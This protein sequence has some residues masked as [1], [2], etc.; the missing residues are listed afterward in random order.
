AISGFENRGSVSAVG[1]KA[2]GILVSDAEFGLGGIRNSGTIKADGTAI[3]LEAFS[4]SQ[5]T[6]DKG[7]HFLKIYQGGG[8]IEGGVAAID[9]RDY[10]GDASKTDLIWSGGTIRGDILGVG[11]H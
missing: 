4:L 3:R 5:E 6:H 11:G 1:D 10:L 9:A 8:L 2:M 7:E